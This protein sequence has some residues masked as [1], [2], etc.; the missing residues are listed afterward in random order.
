MC[1]NPTMVLDYL[2]DGNNNFKEA[3]FYPMYGATRCVANDFDKDGDIDFGV[4]STFPDYERRPE[5]AFVYL[6]NQDSKQFAFKEATFAAVNSGRWLLLDSGDVDK[7]GDDDIILSSFTY[8]FTPVP[9]DLKLH[10]K[11]KSYDLMILENQLKNP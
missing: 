5:Y 6:E 11:E 2:N 7:D 10:W 1:T 4:L 3:F 9:N 8:S